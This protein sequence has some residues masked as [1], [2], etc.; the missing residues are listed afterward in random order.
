MKKLLFILIISISLNIVKGEEMINRK[1]YCEKLTKTISS[2]DSLVNEIFKKSS[3]YEELKDYKFLICPRVILDSSRCFRVY[4][5]IPIDSS[6]SMGNVDLPDD[7]M[8]RVQS[9]VY[10]WDINYAD[11]VFESSNN[12]FYPILLKVA[13]VKGTWLE[14]YSD[15][16]IIADHGRIISDSLGNDSLL[17]F[18]VRVELDKFESAD[19]NRILPYKMFSPSKYFRSNQIKKASRRELVNKNIFVIRETWIILYENKLYSEKC[20]KGKY[21]EKSVNFI[22]ENHLEEICDCDLDEYFRVTPEELNKIK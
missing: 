1:H 9:P 5:P 20:L 13:D 12:S 17:F 10:I 18:S 16:E 6:K 15:K 11:V 3:R 7:L 8:K 22:L 4:P 19:T 21:P 2:N 14:F